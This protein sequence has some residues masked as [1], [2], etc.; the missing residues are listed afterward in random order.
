MQAKCPVCSNKDSLKESQKCGDF[1][2][3][4]CNNCGLE[5]AWP[6]LAGSKE[7]YRQAYFLRRLAPLEKVTDN[8]IIALKNLAPK[9]KILDIGC[10]EGIFVNYAVKNGHQ[11]WGLDFS[12]EMIEIAKARCPG[13]VFLTG[14]LENFLRKYPGEK[15][16]AIA[17]FEIIEHL[18]DP[19]KLVTD[20]RAIL[21]PGGKLVISVPNRDC[22]PVRHFMDN[23]P[24]HLTRWNKQSLLYLSKKAGFA[25][26]EIRTT[27]FLSSAHF[28]LTYLFT[29]LPFY[30]LFRQQKQFLGKLETKKEEKQL[31]GIPVAFFKKAGPF[32]RKLRNAMF[33]PLVL[34][35][36]P[37]LLPIIRGNTY[38]LTAHANQIAPGK[39]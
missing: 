39:S 36:S 13:A 38:V 8:F 22:W 20:A 16:D 21:L 32:L 37:I 26:D 15:F 1:S 11:A 5:F 24:Q 10:G 33:W 3:F 30:T 19:L 23:P 18:S 29:Q 12:E 28:F 34:I 14:T 35:L 17:M 27:R 2:I 7:W 9:S 25:V 4:H 31:Q 6:L